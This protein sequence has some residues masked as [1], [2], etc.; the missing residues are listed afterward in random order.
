MRPSAHLLICLTTLT[1]FCSNARAEDDAALDG[2]LAL[3]DRWVEAHQSY[4]AIPALSVGVVRDQDLIWQKSW[5]LANPARKISANAETLYSICSLSKMF[6][7][8]ALMQQRDAG[9]L[10]LDDPVSAHLPE[11]KPRQTGQ[12]AGPL[13]VRGLL[14]HSSGLSR[15]TLGAY[16]S[17]P[18]FDFPDRE[19]LLAALSK[20]RTLDAPDR[21]FHYSNLGI[22]LAGEIVARKSGETYRDYLEANVL[23]PLEMT[24]TRLEFPRRARSSVMAVGHGARRRDGTRPVMPAFDT[25][26]IEAAA[27]LTSNLIDLARFA[28]WNFRTLDGVDNKILDTATLRD[29]QRVHWV[30]PDWRTTWGLAFEVRKSG[31]DTLVGHEGACPGFAS[32][33][34]LFP[35]HKV[36]VIV[37]ASASGINPN[38]IVENAQKL[39]LPAL[40]QTASEAARH[41]NRPADAERRRLEPYVGRY[42]AQPWAGEVAVIRHGAELRLMWLPSDDVTAGLVTLRHLNDDIFFRVDNEREIRGDRFTFL[43]DENG[44]VIGLTNHALRLPRMR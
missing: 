23:Q 20:Q 12:H 18:D 19:T 7:G 34:A 24:E 39:V 30:D 1:L 36:A 4:N 25:E 29:M 2:A 31:E 22:A 32:S 3:F 21:H 11:F 6:A 27:G 14:T 10:N 26:G 33:L 38:V 35:E 42:D 37:L 17:P 44:E 28:V 13:T 5:G 9:A 40:A 41:R 8:I 43:R 16:W 15:E